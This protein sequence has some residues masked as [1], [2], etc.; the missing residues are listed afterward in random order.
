MKKSILTIALSLIGS[1]AFSQTIGVTG[2]NLTVS[3]GTTSVGD[4]LTLTINGANSIGNVES[5]NMLLATGPA[6][7]SNGSSFFTIGS[8]TPTS[9]FTLTNS[10]PANVAFNTS[11]DAANSGTTVSNP[12][13]DVG[14][15]APAANA[16]AVNGSGTTSIPFETINF[17][18]APNTPVGTYSF[19]V[20]LG[21][22]NDA[23]GSWIDNSSNATF[24]INS[25][26]VFTITVA[27]VPEP[28]SLALIACGIAACGLPLV[29]ARKRA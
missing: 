28:S 11:G 15:N 24:D 23:Q 8:V 4:Q 10:N 27:A 5:V 14:S 16:P 17:A 9:P 25:A 6:G 7:G 3:Q 2:Q 29:R 13:T 19:R 21:G 18:L 1:Y 22:I 12:S 26:P 20:T